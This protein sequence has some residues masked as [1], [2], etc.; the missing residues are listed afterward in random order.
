MSRRLSRQ[1]ERLRWKPFPR[2][3]EVK[4]SEPIGPRGE[5]WLVDEALGE[6]EQVDEKEIDSDP[7]RR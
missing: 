4:P 3:S 2:R 5:V 6:I 1:A 7:N